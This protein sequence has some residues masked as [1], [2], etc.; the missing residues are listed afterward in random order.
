[1]SWIYIFKS[2]E[3]LNVVDNEVVFRKFYIYVVI[4]MFHTHHTY[5]SKL[6]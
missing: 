1:M 3:F 4:I 5:A 6:A 2:S